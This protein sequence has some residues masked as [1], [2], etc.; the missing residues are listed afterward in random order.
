[1]ADWF[2]KGQSNYDSSSGF[3]MG[4]YFDMNGFDE[5]VYQTIKMPDDVLKG[6]PFMAIAAETKPQWT[7]ASQNLEFGLWDHYRIKVN[8][9]GIFGWHE[10]SGVWL[11]LFGG[12]GGV[13]VTGC[14]NNIDGG[15]A[16]SAYLPCQ[17]FDGGSA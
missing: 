9:N 2:M 7:P 13:G 17:N 5:G 16:D 3:H 10:A 1:M 8:V 12:G 4:L 15:R 14:D 6:D 11:S